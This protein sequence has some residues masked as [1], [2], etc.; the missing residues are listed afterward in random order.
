MEKITPASAVSVQNL[1]KQYGNLSAVDHM[2]FDVSAGTCFGSLGPNG[3]GKT[4]LIRI[5][6]GLIKPSSGQAWVK[7][8][9]ISKYPEIV[10]RHIGVVSQAMTTD[11][12]LTGRENLDIYAR[13]FNTE[14]KMRTRRIVELLERIGLT[15][16]ADDLVATY[17]G[18]MR[19][20]LEIARGLIHRPSI[21]FL[22]E[23][24]IGLDPQSRRVVWELLQEFRQDEELTIFLTTHYMDEA[25]ILCEQIAIIDHGKVVVLDTPEGLKKNIP[26]E[27]II[28]VTIEHKKE[29]LSTENQTELPHIDMLTSKLSGFTFVQDVSQKKL[30]TRS[31]LIA[32][33]IY[34][35]NGV[36]SIPVLM[37]QFQ[38]WGY[39]V[40]TIGL[41]QASLEDVFIH[42]TGKSIRKEEGQKV[43]FFI[44]AGVPRKMG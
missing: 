29:I 23:P 13:Y 22:D 33:Q 2:S 32:L 15:D 12:D 16:R 44:G 21:L 40:H 30:E 28:D 3:A 19:R 6:S 36:A 1:V 26:G 4:T 7:G 34:V 11:L 38:T 27:N 8:I 39:Q 37:N 41:K 24:T 35:T 14:K 31:S 9:D 10:R 25:D 18:G 42:Y 20:R 5:L 43:N 17:S